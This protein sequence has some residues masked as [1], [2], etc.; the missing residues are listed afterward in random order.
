MLLQR[1]SKF[2]GL[3]LTTISLAGCSFL[4]PV[5]KEWTDSPWDSF[6]ET[7]LAFDQIV[8]KQTTLEDLKT[9][10]FHPYEDHNVAVL[11]YMDVYKEFV[12][13][14]SVSLADQDPAIQPCFQARDKCRG[15]KVWVSRYRDKQHGNLFLSMFI[16]RREH[17]INEWD[18]RGLIVLID[19][20]VEYKL[21]SGRPQAV[22]EKDRIWPLGPIQDPFGLLK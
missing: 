5:D 8:P 7:R 3:T 2:V 11:T 21:W 9:L 1:V 22:S 4:L 10:G 20:R 6:E 13:N 18:F 17:T 12:P 19:D 15:L 16:F 14:A